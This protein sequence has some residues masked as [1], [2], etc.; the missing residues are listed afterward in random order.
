MLLTR[1][2][3]H[4]GVDQL[5]RQGELALLCG[6]TRVRGEVRGEV[7]VD[8]EA[9]VSGYISILFLSRREEG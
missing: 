2:Q 6:Q 8:E 7:D 3:E 4:P 1:V 9:G 5:L